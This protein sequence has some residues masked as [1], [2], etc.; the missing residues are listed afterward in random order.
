MSEVAEYKFYRPISM[1]PLVDGDTDEVLHVYCRNK[2]TGYER[3]VSPEEADALK[4]AF[5]ELEKQY[6]GGFNNDDGVSDSLDH[7]F[8][9]NADLY[10]KFID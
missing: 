6:N 2:I 7:L 3:L 1:V 10:F 9:I 5:D 4:K 8:K